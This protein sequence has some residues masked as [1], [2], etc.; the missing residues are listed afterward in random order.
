MFALT[1]V[2]IFALVAGIL[3]GGVLALWRWGRLQGRFA[4]VGLTT[5]VG[6]TLWY[7]TLN[8]TSAGPN[9]DIDAPIVRVSWADAGS[10]VF[11]FLITALVLGLIV[12]RKEPAGR[13]VGAAALAGLIAT[14][15]D[16]FV[17]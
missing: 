8:A 17:L 14:I 7:L 12:D 15:L 16:I 5:F 2:L 10:G 4:V 9:F 6:F 11:A 3:A 13:V 1:S